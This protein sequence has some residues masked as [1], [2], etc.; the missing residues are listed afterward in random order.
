[1]RQISLFIRIVGTCVFCVLLSLNS[2]L[3]QTE[4]GIENSPSVNEKSK[5]FDAKDAFLDALSPFTSLPIRDRNFRLNTFFTN[6]ERQSLK[7]F[8]AQRFSAFENFSSRR[9]F[10]ARRGGIQSAFST[11]TG[12]TQIWETQT[13]EKRG[14]VSSNGQRPTS[15]EFSV[16]NLSANLGVSF[17]ETSLS[18]NIG[19]L[20][21][22]TASGSTNSFAT[23]AQTQEVAVKTMSSV[24]E[25]RVAGA[26]INFSSRSGNNQY[27]GSVFE[28]FGNEKLNAND[29]FAKSLGFE[30]SAAR[31]NQFGGALGGFF[32]KDKAW[33]FGGYEGLRLRQAGFAV[34]EVPNFSARQ[35]ASAEI[36]PLF[37]AFPV[38]N[39]RET[40]NGF[41]E[42]SAS[43]T[44]P[45]EH[46][47][48]GLR[49]DTQ[50]L[51]NLRI[52]GR[53][54][55]ADSNAA[56]RGDKD[57]S[58]N[59]LRKFETK[60]NSFSAWTTY[61]AS[62][63]VVIDGRV[64][65]SRNR[66]GQQFSTDNFGGAS[67]S[68]VSPLDFLKYDFGGKNSAIAVGNP[69]ETV[70]KQFQASGMVDWVFRTHQ[71]TFGA[72][73]R[74]L[75]LDIGAA[76]RER[77]V[78]FA[79]INQSLGGTAAR[80]TEL[81]RS[82]SEKPEVNNFSFFVQDNWRITN[83]LV[84][85]LG[86]RQ[87]ADFA[88]KIEMPTAEFQNASP[89][90][91]NRS[92]NFAP[93]ASVAFDLL[94][95]G[96]AILRGGV[97]LYFDYGTAAASDVFANSFPFASGNFARNSL[98]TA[99]PTNSLK[100]LLAFADDLQTPRTWHIFAEYQQELFRNHIFTATYTASLG[101]KLF[102]TRTFLN[103][104]PNFNYVRLTNNDA[105]SD[106]NS[107]QLRY[108]RRFSQGFSLNARYALSKSKDNFSPDALRETNFV[109]ADLEQERGTSDFDVRQQFNIYGTYDIPTV[110]SNGWAKRLTE[111]WSISAF[112]N[113]RTAF[114]LSAGFFRV[115]DFGK[116]FIRADRTGNAPVYLNENT[117]K[118]LNPNAFSIPNASRQGTLER[119]SLRG[120]P[121]FQLDTSLQKRIRFTNEMRLELS[122][123]AYNLL[124]NTNF[125]DMD[126]SLG[127]LVS[128]GNFQPNSYFGK[129]TSTFGSANFTPFYLYGGART[130]QLSAKFVF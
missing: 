34:S 120:F 1:M 31:L 54:N 126:G 103:N 12:I 127:T 118:S 83:R 67:V 129:A 97:G 96:R 107:L 8:S 68:I 105:E 104:D 50:P 23:S 28:T 21:T 102:L 114:P 13:F 6:S 14:I 22:L 29:T 130:I 72:D 73:F 93:R 123:N 111:D 18:R 63:W 33:F 98:F 79:G 121:L 51:R 62:P 82:I 65:F 10:N 36:R 3:A 95:R 59:T 116:E 124:N 106:F 84:L 74:R 71:F 5:K 55:F 9:V 37:N 77:S 20:P 30:R 19:A 56:I 115:N 38:Q 40:S 4:T 94:G 117:I 80:I 15:N 76:R 69:L 44:N 46:D 85:N 128:N 89:Q 61:T 58:L 122:I 45:A 70:V 24:K 57:F 64:N 60:S 86:L 43:Y 66:L 2:L 25:Q 110:F 41:A 119:N 90:M 81:T 108:E 88:P 92:G 48:F 26:Q 52:G 39:G 112:A 53:F 7:A 87:D 49:I 47:I 75:S 91:P 78:L 100:P 35:A 99:A 16:D 32:W 113:A 125:A 11:A 27:H 42:F 101:R 17:D 109:A